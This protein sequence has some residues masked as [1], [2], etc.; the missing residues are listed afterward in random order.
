MSPLPLVLEDAIGSAL[1]GPQ[2]HM[3]VGDG[4]AVAYQREIS[5]LGSL[6]LNPVSQTW[7]ALDALPVDEIMPATAGSLAV[8]A[9]WR[10]L[11]EFPACLMT[12]DLVEI[13]EPRSAPTPLDE[14][15]LPEM[16]ELVERTRPGPF[17][18]RTIDFGGYVGIR[19]NGSLVAM[20]GQRTQP[21]G[22]T[23]ISAVCTDPQYRGQ[24]LA[25]D[26]VHSVLAGIR[27]QSRRGFLYVAREN[28]AMD[29]YKRLGFV[30]QREYVVTH[31]LRDVATQPPDS[32]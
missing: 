19:R 6:G 15:D 20:A 12:D 18:P 30:N 22:W 9:G 26:V 7:Q 3:A 25:K 5:A 1:R 17:R 27:T 14:D 11:G 10:S 32:R 23:E 29:L 16:M 8:G 2:R 21:P 4:A 24:G 31:L 28:P 13:K